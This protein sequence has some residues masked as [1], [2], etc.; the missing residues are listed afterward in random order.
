MFSVDALWDR[1]DVFE[2][3]DSLRFVFFDRKGISV[4][5][6][7]NS[8]STPKRCFGAALRSV[9]RCSAI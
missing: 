8:V 2:M 4:N 7:S 6:C 9:L 5:L 1:V 3:L